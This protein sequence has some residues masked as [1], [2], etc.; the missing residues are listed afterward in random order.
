MHTLNTCSY[1][2]CA[3]ALP[4]FHNTVKKSVTDCVCSSV[5]IQACIL[6]CWPAYM[7]RERDWCHYIIVHTCD[8]GLH[9]RTRGSRGTVT[10]RSTPPDT[11]PQLAITLF[12]VCFF[13]SLTKLFPLMVHCLRRNVC[14]VA[15]MMSVC[16]SLH[17]PFNH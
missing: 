1:R 8:F 6:I 16:V 14:M 7:H 2:R 11:L 15:C 12:L 4:L 10:R 9:M 3:H 5:N 17:D 13:D